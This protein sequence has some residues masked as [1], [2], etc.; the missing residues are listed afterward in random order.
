MAFLCASC[1]KNK[2]IWERFYGYTKAEILGNYEA[3][4]DSELYEELPT[5]GVSFLKDWEDYTMY[6]KE[7]QGF[8]RG[9]YRF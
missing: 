5:E 3:N 8:F 4:P 7:C 1:G 6:T 2:N 9:F